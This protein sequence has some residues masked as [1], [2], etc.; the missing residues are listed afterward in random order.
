MNPTNNKK[1]KV[2]MGL[3]SEFAKA[4]KHSAYLGAYQVGTSV[5]WPNSANDVD[6]LV[7]GAQNNKNPPL[8]NDFVKTIE[9][10]RSGGIPESPFDA[11]SPYLRNTI[12]KAVETVSQES[13]I[14]IKAYYAVG[15]LPQNLDN[16]SNKIAIHI[17]GTLSK[18]EAAYFFERLPFHGLAF[19]AVNCKL[20][21]K[22][23][24]ETFKKPNPTQQEYSELIAA[25]FN[26]AKR[27]ASKIEKY[28]CAKK[29]VLTRYLYEESMQP[30]EKTRKFM[31]GKS[32]HYNNTSSKEALLNYAY[33]FAR[34][35]LP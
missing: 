34:E 9:T 35:I 25:L 4:F 19:F 30:Y 8:D 33:E 6:L 29:I 27:N 12:S 13:D 18:K 28:N 2:I 21:G 20:C 31:N 22:K 16:E 24:S 3:V 17:C 10:I 5:L 15:P 7:I 11:S 14:K 32:K 26:R 1:S 23:L